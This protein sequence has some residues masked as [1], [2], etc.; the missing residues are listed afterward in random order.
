MTTAAAAAAKSNMS[1]KDLIRKHMHII[2]RLTKFRY[3]DISQTD[4]PYSLQQ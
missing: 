1:K 2:L 4:R 3:S